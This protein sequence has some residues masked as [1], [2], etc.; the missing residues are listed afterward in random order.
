MEPDTYSGMVRAWVKVNRWKPYLGFGY[1]GLLSKREK[2]WRLSCDCGVM[3]WGGTPKIPTHDGVDLARDVEDLW[4]RV[5]TNVRFIKFFKA[6]PVVDL[7]LTRSFSLTKQHH[8]EDA[9]QQ[10]LDNY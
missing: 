9:H 2:H 10:L 5:G 3:F 6:F 4:G 7:R 1:G 8:E